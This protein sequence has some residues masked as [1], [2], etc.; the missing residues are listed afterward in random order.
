MPY[1][2]NQ[3]E[4][5]ISDNTN[6]SVAIL[7][8]KDKI[9]DQESSIIYDSSGE[10][11]AVNKKKNL[12]DQAYEKLFNKQINYATKVKF[13]AQFSD[14]NANISLSNNHIELRLCRKWKQIDQEI[15]LG[16]VQSL[17]LKILKKDR[18]PNNVTKR[19]ESIN[20]DVYNK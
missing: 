5:V 9:G 2:E 17:L 8:N 6:N 15:V 20:I 19:H 7:R 18:L 11:L 3:Q 10:I 16:L 14:Y 1:Q 13:T 12:I 4:S